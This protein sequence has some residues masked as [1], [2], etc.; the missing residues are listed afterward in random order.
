VILI[1]TL[2]ADAFVVNVNQVIGDVVPLHSKFA[3][4]EEEVA[5]VLHTPSKVS[6]IALEQVEPCDKPDR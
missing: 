2:S 1:K 6:V 4:V 3:P 5:Y